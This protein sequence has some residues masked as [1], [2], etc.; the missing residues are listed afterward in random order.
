MKCN[1]SYKQRWPVE[2]HLVTI[3]TGSGTPVV[4]PPNLS[5]H[6]GH[7]VYFK[8][9]SKEGKANKVKAIVFLPKDLSVEPELEKLKTKVIKVKGDECEKLKIYDKCQYGTYPYAIY[10]IEDNTFVEVNSP[11]T[12]IIKNDE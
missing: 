11:P 2:E 6:A 9:E 12:M 1:E 3:T 8:V 4:S 10:S 7:T 5:C